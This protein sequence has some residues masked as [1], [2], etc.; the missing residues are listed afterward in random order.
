[1]SAA[2]LA[3]RDPGGPGAYLPSMTETLDAAPETLAYGGTGRPSVPR[4][5]TP[6]LSLRR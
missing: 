5:R 1:M 4:Y 6:P 2:A 3:G